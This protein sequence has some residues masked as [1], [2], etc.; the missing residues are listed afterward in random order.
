MA[1]IEKHSTSKADLLFN[2]SQLSLEEADTINLSDCV[3]VRLHL[4]RLAVTGHAIHSPITVSNIS[5]SF[6]H[7]SGH[8]PTEAALQD[9]IWLNW[10]S[11]T[12]RTAQATSWCMNVLTYFIGSCPRNSRARGGR[13]VKYEAF[14]LL[15]NHS[16][17]VNVGNRSANGPV[18]SM[19][20][21][22]TPFG[23]M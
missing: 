10:S 23:G 22:E 4:G 1:P 3:C 16:T 13:A 19:N 6:T 15:Q 8:V 17:T 12:S 5:L 20:V 2:W 14:C 9:Q 18:W 7:S 21:E 11:V